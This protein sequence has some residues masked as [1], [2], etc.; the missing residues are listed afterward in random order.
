MIASGGARISRVQ[1]D[2]NYI[3]LTVPFNVLNGGIVL[4]ASGIEVDE[5]GNIITLSKPSIVNGSQTQGVIKEFLDEYDYQN[6]A[7]IHI[8]FELIVTEESD[9]VGEISISRNFQNDVKPLS[10]AGRRGYF[11]E[12]NEVIQNAFQGKKLSTSETERPNEHILDTEKL[13]KIIAALT[14]QDLWLRS[15][16]MN[17]TYTYDRTRTCLKEYEEIYR[18]AHDR[19]DDKHKEYTALYEFYLD[20]ASAAWCL[21]QK[22]KSHQGFRGTWLKSI[23]RKGP[24]IVDVPEGIVWP[25]LAAHSE[26]VTRR[27]G[28]WTLEI[29]ENFD[30]DRLIS[31]AKN[32]YMEI[33][34][35]KPDVMGKSRACYSS[36]QTIT[37]IYREFADAAA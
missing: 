13:L 19:G 11:D 27:A 32:A 20:I 10:I 9:L 16:E 4:V 3:N 6:D 7:P 21:Y 5:K 34:K 23:T 17:K 31:A 37:A 24:K 15:G 28:A 1:K 22:W 18:Q 36:L 2:K 35:S 26:F 30:E 25:I 12:L 33:A 8:K 29:P 14:P